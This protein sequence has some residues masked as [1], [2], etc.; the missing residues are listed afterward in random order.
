[1]ERAG[2]VRRNTRGDYYDYFRDR[3]IFPITDSQGRVIAMG[4]R[5]MADDSGPKYLNTP[6]TH[7]FMKRNILYGLSLAKPAIRKEEQVY[8]V[9]GYMDTVAMYQGGFENVVASMGTSLSEEQA[10]AISRYT[11]RVIL[12]Y[13]ADTA[14]SAA[15]TRGIEIFEKAGLYVKVMDLPQGEDPDSIIKKKG[16]P[17]FSEL[18]AN[19]RGIIEYKIDNLLQ[20][21]DMKSPESKQE[22][23]KELIPILKEVRGDIRLSEYIR[24]FSER[25]HI[26]EVKLRNILSGVRVKK[27]ITDESPIYN[28]KFKLP[29]ELLLNCLLTNPQFISICPDYNINEKC[30]KPGLYVIYKAIVDSGVESKEPLSVDILSRILKTEEQLKTAIDLAVKEG[31]NG[32]NEEQVRI[33]LDKIEHRRVKDEREINFS[34]KQNEGT[35]D[36]NDPDFREYIESLRKLKT[37]GANS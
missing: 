12:A 9:E 30:M 33:I 11:R 31:A 17:F 15:T 13:D 27:Q 23:V 16:A 2:I 36:Y 22:F 14:G 5:S 24:L 8:V 18:S 3:L 4:G 32:C 26:N 29:E 10:R 7:I 35:L 1:M 20:K 21:Y 28:K 34:K 37:P 19:S 25:Y 6:E